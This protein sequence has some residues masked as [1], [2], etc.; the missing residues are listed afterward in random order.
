M[1]NMLGYLSVEVIIEA[2]YSRID[3]N[4]KLFKP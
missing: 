3:Q 4:K 2:A 1:D